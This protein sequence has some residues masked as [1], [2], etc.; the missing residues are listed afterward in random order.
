MNADAEFLKLVREYVE[1]TTT[2]EIHKDP[3]YAANVRRKLSAAVQ[4]IIQQGRGRMT[5]RKEFK[6]P[7][8]EVTYVIETLDGHW[9][10]EATICPFCG[11][12]Y[13][14]EEEDYEDE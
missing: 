9:S 5:D 7:C 1:A 11:W 12:D 14:Y 2:V 8:C 4:E 6:C 13:D 3:V 10:D